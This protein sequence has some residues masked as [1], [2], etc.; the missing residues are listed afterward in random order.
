M[1]IEACSDNSMIEMFGLTDEQSKL[2]FSA[3]R[4]ITEDKSTLVMKYETTLLLTMLI[5]QL[6]R[7][8]MI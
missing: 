7:E 4:M 1:A 8:M 2:L 5:P 3:Q 6:D